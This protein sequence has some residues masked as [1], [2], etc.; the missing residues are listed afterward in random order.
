MSV[1]A[2]TVP[3]LFVKVQLTSLRLNFLPDSC[4]KQATMPERWRRG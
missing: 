3:I 4:A 2:Q 1:I